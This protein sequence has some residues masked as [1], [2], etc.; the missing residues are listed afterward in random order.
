MQVRKLPNDEDLENRTRFGPSRAEIER[1]R[2]RLK[3]SNTILIICSVIQ[4]VYL[5]RALIQLLIYYK[6]I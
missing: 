4:F 6:V 2:K 5:I 3:I 1:H